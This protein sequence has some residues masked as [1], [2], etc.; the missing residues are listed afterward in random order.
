[1]RP[2]QSKAD[3]GG[4]APSRAAACV[5]ARHP[6]AASNEEALEH[7]V[8][9]MKSTVVPLASHDTSRPPDRLNLPAFRP[10]ED[11]SNAR[12]VSLNEQASTFGGF[13]GPIAAQ[14]GTFDSAGNPEPLGWNDAISE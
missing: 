8:Q 14:L 9:V 10:L 3:T 13:D 4:A 1:M 11:A 5:T 6:S 2:E 12:R 7:L